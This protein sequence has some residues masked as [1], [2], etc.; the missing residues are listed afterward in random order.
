MSRW[1]VLD[2]HPMRSSSFIWR[3]AL[4]TLRLDIDRRGGTLDHYYHFIMDLAWPLWHWLDATGRSVEG[5]S[6]LT[7]DPRDQYF[8]EVMLELLGV[9]MEPARETPTTPAAVMLRGFNTVAGDQWQTFANVEA[10]R[11]A[12]RRFVQ[13]VAGRTGGAAE[14]PPTVVLIRR[15]EGATDRAAA[16]RSIADH[17]R[18]AERVR[19]HAHSRSFVFLDLQLEHLS[20]R[21]QVRLLHDGPVILIGQHGAGLVNGVWM[22]HVHSVVIELADAD[23]PPHYESLCKDLGIRYERLPCRGLGGLMSGQRITVD[24]DALEAAIDSTWPAQ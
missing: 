21:H 17:D 15:E 8:D 12:R 22:T 11:A 13:A 20:P 9:A 18:L 2:G 7:F 3:S 14:S 24:A 4:E 1:R 6:L 10:F 19:R 16:R 23:N 5:G